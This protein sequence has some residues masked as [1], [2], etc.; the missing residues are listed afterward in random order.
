MRS[1]ATGHAPP[2]HASGQSGAR[3]ASGQSG[4]RH[5]T[6]RPARSRGRL[7]LALLVALVV[8]ALAL[9]WLTGTP[10]I[11]AAPGAAPGAVADPSTNE[12]VLRVQTAGGLGASPVPAPP[13]VT[14]YADGFAV[15]AD[16]ATD[17]SLTGLS[18]RTLDAAALAR[19]LD[20]AA[21]ARLGEAFADATDPDGQTTTFTLAR[22]NGSAP[23]A[24]Q[25]AVLGPQ[26]G[27]S[28][29]VADRRAKA[30][31]YLTQLRA[32]DTFGPGVSAPAPYTP[33]RLA[34]SA[35]PA[36]GGGGGSVQAWPAADV[37]LAALSDAGSCV[38]VDGTSAGAI[39]DALTGAPANTQWDED[40]QLWQVFASP[41]LPDQAGCPTTAAT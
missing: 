23:V 31:A 6:D 33:A 40:G 35:R 19:L 2:R 39:R 25:F 26:G 1:T 5:A 10:S 28:P 21:A 30:A 12:V 22:G 27:D 7:L 17:Q 13:L 41:L 29:D 4:A 34:V 8:G 16:T 37:S 18:A 38:V 20:A 36:L 15:L 11:A 24:S 14:V 32:L 9:A 3:H